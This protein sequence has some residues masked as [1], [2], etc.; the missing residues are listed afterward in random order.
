MK[1]SPH[2]NVEADGA[3]SDEADYIVY[4]PPAP[5]VNSSSSSTSGEGRTVPLSDGLWQQECLAVLQ[6]YADKGKFS[7]VAP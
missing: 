5:T 3:M 1:E 2:G 7:P 6:M 4:Q